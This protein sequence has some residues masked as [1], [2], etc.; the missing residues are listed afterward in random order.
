VLAI[1]FAMTDKMINKALIF[2]VL[3]SRQQELKGYGVKRIGLFGSFVRGENKVDSD[4]D[5]LVDFQKE[6]KSL[7][8]LV[9]LGDYLEGL[10]GRKVDLVTPQGLSKF[11]GPFILKEV[12]YATF[13]D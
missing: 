13:R 10:F 7:H 9:N 11:I 6:K 5:F 4:I 1:F 8:N 2:N 3:Q 12:Q